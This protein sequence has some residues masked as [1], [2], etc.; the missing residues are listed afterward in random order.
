MSHA[1]KSSVAIPAHAL[2]SITIMRSTETATGQSGNCTQ[3]NKWRECFPLE[4]FPGASDACENT[5]R[6]F[7]FVCDLSDSVFSIQ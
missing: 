2:I 1:Y 7:W 3:G 6:I 5:A 4:C